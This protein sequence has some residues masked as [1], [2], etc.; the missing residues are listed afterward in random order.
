MGI[1]RICGQPAGLF[2]REHKACR[3]TRTHTWETM[4]STATEA[5]IGKGDA[6]SLEARLAQLAAGGLAPADWARAAAIRGFENA[7]KT[8]MGH[9]GITEE[10]EAALNTFTNALHLSQED[11]DG[12]GAFSNVVRSAV[13]RQV[14]AGRVPERRFNL[15][16]TLPFNFVH[17]ETLVWVFPSAT[18]LELRT[19]THFEGGSQG[20]SVRIM[21]GVS[22]RVGAYRGNPVQATNAVTV[23]SGPLAVTTKSIYFDTPGKSFRIPYAKIVTFHPYSDGFGVQRDAANA[24]PQTFVTGDGWFAFG[25]V[26]GLAH[27]NAQ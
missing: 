25:L 24:K 21:K 13:L 3:A 6:G 23:G 8:E 22:Y 1:C 10:H 18:Y 9:D 14:L 19:S 5:A 15:V 2:R 11:L 12:N 16:G 4:V 7:V 27:M 17:D 20:V 26:T